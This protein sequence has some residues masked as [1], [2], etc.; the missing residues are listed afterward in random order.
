MLSLLFFCLDA[1]EKV[2]KEKIKAAL[3]GLLRSGVTLKK[4]E[5]ASLKQL[6]LLYAP[7]H[8]L[9]FTP[10]QRNTHLKQRSAFESPV[11]GPAFSGGA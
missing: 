4:K 2:T 8:S 3:F 7:P 5:L 6:F 11:G 1:K 9:R 10:H